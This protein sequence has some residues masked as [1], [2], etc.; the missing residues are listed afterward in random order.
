MSHHNDHRDLLEGKT[1]KTDD[2]SLWFWPWRLPLPHYVLLQYVFAFAVSQPRN[3]ES[4]EGTEAEEEAPPSL[5][6]SLPVTR[7]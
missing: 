7:D 5:A 2:F 6:R 3:A 4:L 1:R